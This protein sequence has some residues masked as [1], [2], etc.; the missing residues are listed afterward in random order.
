M[1]SIWVHMCVVLC[2][3]DNDQNISST[4]ERQVDSWYQLRRIT[5]VCNKLL[6]YNLTSD[7]IIPT[8]KLLFLN[9]FLQWVTTK[10][11]TFYQHDLLYLLIVSK[12]FNTQTRHVGTMVPV[13]FESWSQL[14]GMIQKPHN[15]LQSSSIASSRLT[16]L[17]ERCS[18]YQIKVLADSFV[19]DNPIPNLCQSIQTI[20]FCSKHA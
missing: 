19:V 13:P 3:C 4:L 6:I 10:C 16:K 20:P 15:C 14:M 9:G 17:V 11:N 8:I 7:Q 5:Y 12:C 18:N 2:I 1:Q